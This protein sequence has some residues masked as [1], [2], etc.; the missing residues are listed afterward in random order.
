MLNLVAL[1]DLSLNRLTG[2]NGS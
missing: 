2:W 1:N